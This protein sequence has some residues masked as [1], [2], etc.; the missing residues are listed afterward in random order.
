MWTRLRLPL[1]A[2]ETPSPL[3]R[4]AA[5]SDFASGSASDLDFERFVSINPDLTLHI[6]REPRSDWIGI[7]GSSEIRADG[8]GQSLGTLYDLHGRI[9]RAQT[10]LYVAAR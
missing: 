7:V 4:L 10:S 3:V 8:T 6:E 5:T 1:V 9:A 2:G